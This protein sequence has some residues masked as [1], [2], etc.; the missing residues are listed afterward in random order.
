MNTPV[1][2]PVTAEQVQRINDLFEKV[3]F[4]LLSD[5]N[6]AYLI[7]T[8]CGGRTGRPEQL[9]F[10][11]ANSIIERLLEE[12]RCRE[13]EKE[14]KRKREQKPVTAEK[15]KKIHTLLKKKGL[16]EEKETMLDSI[17]DG[18]AAHTKDLTCEEAR[19]WIAFLTDDK[20]ALQDKQVELKNS[21]WCAA[22]DMGL[23]YGDTDDDYEMNKAKLNMFCRQRGTVKKNIEEQNLFELRKTFRQ[24]N[25]MYTKFINKVSENE[26]IST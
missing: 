14:E 10:D 21:I 6:K 4:G 13:S 26:R 15:I 23:I 9:T 3:Y 7:K 11:E 17:S 2:K 20:A 18:R 12:V 16:M 5:E 1:I 8:K 24:F 25:E 22:W 19:Q